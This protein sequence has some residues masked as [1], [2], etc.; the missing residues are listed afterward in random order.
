MR[1]GRRVADLAGLLEARAWAAA[2]LE[3]LPEPLRRLEDGQIP[4][5]ISRGIR[6]LATSLDQQTETANAD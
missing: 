6:N 3:T 2:A 5:E 4:V 1:S